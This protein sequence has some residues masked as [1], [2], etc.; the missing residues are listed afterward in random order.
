MPLTMLASWPEHHRCRPSGAPVGLDAPRRLPGRSAAPGPPGIQLDRGAIGDDARVVPAL[1]LC[2][3][4]CWNMWSQRDLAE[5]KLA[6]SS[7]PA[8]ALQL[9]GWAAVLFYT[10]MVYI[11]LDSIRAEA[12]NGL[13]A[14]WLNLGQAVGINGGL[15]YAHLGDDGC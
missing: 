3:S 14:F 6:D 7:V 15:S 4:P 5:T 9:V 10:S 2:R 11:P 8:W 13:D 12:L 1:A